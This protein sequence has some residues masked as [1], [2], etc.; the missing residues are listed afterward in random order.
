MGI[1]R[2][3]DAAHELEL[4]WV[5]Q[6]GKVRQLGRADPVLT[7][8]GPTEVDAGGQNVVDESVAHLGVGL[9]HRKVDVAV[10]GMA[11]SHHQ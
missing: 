6:S 10:T 4:H 3:L 1:E 5:L 2:R 9:E 11:A 7:G 8:D